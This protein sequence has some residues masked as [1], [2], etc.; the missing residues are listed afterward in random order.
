MI[1]VDGKLLKLQCFTPFFRSGSRGRLF[2]GLPRVARR[3]LE[4]LG[5]AKLRG[6][7]SSVVF[8][9]FGGGWG[10]CRSEAGAQCQRKRPVEATVRE[11]QRFEILGENF[12]RD[13]G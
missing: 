9:V 11:D 3:F 1:V 10:H 4:N 6:R 12:G 8:A 2:G 13:H 7:G 5:F